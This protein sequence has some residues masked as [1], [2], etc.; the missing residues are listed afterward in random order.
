M[1]RERAAPSRAARERGAASEGRGPSDDTVRTAANVLMLAAAGAAVVYIIRT[2]PLRRAAWQLLRTW[3]AGPAAAWTIN[4]VRESWDES[5][6]AR[7]TAL[8]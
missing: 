7:P 8:V 5:G 1:R 2:P 4:L 3:A 6:K